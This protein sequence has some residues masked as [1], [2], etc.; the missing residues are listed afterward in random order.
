MGTMEEGWVQEVTEGE[1]GPTFAPPTAGSTEVKLCLRGYWSQEAEVVAYTMKGVPGE[2]CKEAHMR[3]EVRM[4]WVGH[5]P[6]EARATRRTADPPAQDRIGQVEPVPLAV[7]VAEGCS[8]E[9]LA[10]L[11]VEEGRH[12]LAQ[13]ECLL[14]TF[15]AT[16]DAKATAASQSLL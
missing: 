2:G 4:A 10:M 14:T 13:L 6:R 8:G 5:K 15:K 1:V 9:A 7:V 3:E 12:F 11:L 16:R